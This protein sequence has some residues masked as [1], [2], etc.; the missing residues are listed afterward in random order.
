MQSVS[1]FLW[2]S[3]DFLFLL[4]C[5]DKNEGVYIEMKNMLISISMA[6]LYFCLAFIFSISVFNFYPLMQN[7]LFSISPFTAMG[8]V[9]IIL[10]LTFIIAFFLIGLI[11]MLEDYMFLKFKP[12]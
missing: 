6:F 9:I 12:N 1:N 11:C 8:I 5:L 2:Y 4:L 7:F 10:F 3:L